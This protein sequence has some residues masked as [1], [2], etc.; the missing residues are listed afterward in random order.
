M[1]HAL[2]AAQIEVDARVDAAVAEV[3]VDRGSIAVAPDELAELAQ[4]AAEAHRVD[5]GI[6][7]AHDRVGARPARWSAVADAPVSRMRPQ[8]R[9]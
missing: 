1:G 5:R 4:V 6:L 8:A 9:P 3:P 7:P 2:A